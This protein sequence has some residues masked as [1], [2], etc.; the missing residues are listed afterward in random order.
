MEGHRPVCQ[1]TGIVV[2]FLQIGMEVRWD[3]TMSVE[4]MVNEA[5]RRAYLR[6]GQR[7]S[8]VDGLPIRSA[9]ADEY[10]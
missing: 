10:A 4:E 3:A 6:S 1:D 5:V 2:V 7:S 9:D 8:R